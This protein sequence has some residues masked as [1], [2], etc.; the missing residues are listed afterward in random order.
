MRKKGSANVVKR[1][2]GK[3]ILRLVSQIV[4]R[5]KPDQ[6]YAVDEK[7]RSVAINDEGI[8][9]V[10]QAL[11]LD[12]LY[13]GNNIILVHH[14]EEALTNS[15]SFRVDEA[16]LRRRLADLGGTRRGILGDLLSMSPNSSPLCS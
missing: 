6:D 16:T 12:R 13:E 4:A 5:L 14:L 8:T 1:I 2:P 11:N 15:L 3:L 10:E 9:K 7:A